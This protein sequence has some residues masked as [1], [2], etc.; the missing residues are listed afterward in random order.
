VCKED[1]LK[2]QTAKFQPNSLIDLF[3]TKIAKKFLNSRCIYPLKVKGPSKE[4]WNWKSILNSKALSV[5]GRQPREPPKTAESSGRQWRL[6]NSQGA[7]KT[8]KS[9]GR[10]YGFT[11][12]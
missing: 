9:I 11:S 5:T 7:K 12:I 8:V 6:Y 3:T 1:F 2:L 4:T 10:I